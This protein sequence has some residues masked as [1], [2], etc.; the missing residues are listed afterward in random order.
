M[1][2]SAVWSVFCGL[3]LSCLMADLKQTVMCEQGTII[4]PAAS[5]QAAG[6]LI[7]LI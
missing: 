2:S 3:F 5:K 6:L 7:V 4:G 1:I